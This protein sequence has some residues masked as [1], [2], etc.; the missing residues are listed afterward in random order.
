MMQTAII[1]GSF[2]YFSRTAHLPKI[3]HLAI[4]LIS[5]PSHD[6]YSSKGPEQHQFNQICSN[7]SKQNSITLFIFMDISPTTQ[8]GSLAPPHRVLFN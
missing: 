5:F 4:P 3:Q 6:S 7:S 1:L 2:E 8:S